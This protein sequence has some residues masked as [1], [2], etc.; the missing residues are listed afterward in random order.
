MFSVDQFG[1]DESKSTQN[2]TTKG[3]LTMRILALGPGN[4]K[5]VAGDSEY[6]TATR[7]RPMAVRS[8]AGIPWM[9]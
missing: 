3:D 2:L 4:Y 5:T 6:L 9:K 8:V 1:S 7:F